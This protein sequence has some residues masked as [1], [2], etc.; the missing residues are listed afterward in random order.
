VSPS[1]SR[2]DLH[3]GPCGSAGCG[4]LPLRFGPSVDPSTALVDFTPD[5]ALQRADAVYVS[6]A[7]IGSGL[8]CL[9][10]QDVLLAE[11]EIAN[12][13]SPFLPA[14]ALSGEGAG[15]SHRNGGALLPTA[16][17]A[18]E[19]GAASGLWRVFVRP[20][21][22]DSSG[23]VYEVLLESS[24]RLHRLTAALIPPRGVDASQV[25]FGGCT[26]PGDPGLGQR[27]C[28]RASELGPY[29]DRGLSSTAGP[30][31]RI[32]P[33]GGHPVALY[34]DLH[35]SAPTPLLPALNFAGKPIL[36]GLL[37][38][39]P[40]VLERVPSSVLAVGLG[41]LDP[42]IDNFTIEEVHLTSGSIGGTGGSPGGDSDGDGQADDQDNC[43]GSVN[44]ADSGGLGSNLPDGIGN[45]CQCGDVINV[46]G[47]IP[48]GIIDQSDVTRIRSALVGAQA[49][50]AAVAVKCNVEGAVDAVLSPV[51]LRKDCDLRE[52]VVLQ[53]A[54]AGPLGTPPAPQKCGAP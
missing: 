51:G 54:L 39:S 33:L 11:V 27:L 38:Y 35:G 3:I 28:T 44:L 50:P 22:G 2:D 10:G 49:I 14:P 20:R 26:E 4:Q 46:Q 32:G 37:R 5:P 31:P 25:S 6:L 17:I 8:L 19:S 36:L 24:L 7:G 9:P 41:P 16:L 23:L 30:D 1:F 40:D 15:P 21:L 42:L 18:H 12:N 13:R 45:D 47:T 34:L 43:V 29:V 53:R 48:D 52:R